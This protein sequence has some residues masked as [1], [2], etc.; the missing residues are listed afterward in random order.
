LG[1]QVADCVGAIEVLGG[2]QVVGVFEDE[3]SSAFSRS[4]GD[5]LESAMR[6][7]E[8]LAQDPGA[9][10]LWVQH[11]DRL[12]R[13]DGR[14]ARHVVEIALWALKASVAVRCVQ[15]ADTFRDLLHAVVIGERN[16]EDS[17]RKG[18]ASAAGIRRAL[19]RGEYC[20]IGLDGYR[21]VVDVD[22]RGGVTK[23]LEFDPERRPLFDLIFRLAAS[24]QRAGGDRVQDQQARLAHRAAT[25][26]RAG[27]SVSAEPHHVCA[28]QPQVCR[29]GGAEGR[30][31]RP[32]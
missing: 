32:R 22:K 2:R 25:Q 27:R 1:T 24:R 11:S 14:I 8:R 18:A 12:A 4:R 16:H 23:R 29:P 19:L 20:G 13:G 9:C 10:E 3:A 26:R 30:D 5:G 6:L 28:R 21:V 17:R 15:D 31:P 7:C